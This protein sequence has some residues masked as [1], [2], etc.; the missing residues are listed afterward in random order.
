MA[1]PRNHEARPLRLLVVED[2]ADMRSMITEIVSSLG[3]SVA[4]V[5]KAKEA[6][7]LIERGAVDIMLLDLNMPGVGGMDVLKVIR[8][9]HLPTPVI[10]VSGY[11]SQEAVTQLSKLNVQG[12]VAKPFK[13]DRIASEIQ[14]VAKAC[15]GS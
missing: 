1:P 2:D 9:R 14:R 8:R 15:Y 7:S 4:E 10:I 12:M 3:Y 13:K 11:I 5:D 6:I